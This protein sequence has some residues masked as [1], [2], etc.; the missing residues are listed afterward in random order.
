MVF[1]SLLFNGLLGFNNSVEFYTGERKVELSIPA[2]QPTDILGLDI[3]GLAL[4]GMFKSPLV[5]LE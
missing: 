2:A 4:D 1:R 3:L 5:D